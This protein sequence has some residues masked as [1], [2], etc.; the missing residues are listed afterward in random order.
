MMV[1]EKKKTDTKELVNWETGDHRP[2]L[3]LFSFVHLTSRDFKFFQ[4]QNT[5]ILGLK[6]LRKRI[7]INP[8]LQWSHKENFIFQNHMKYS[9][10]LHHM[11]FFF[12][13]ITDGGIRI[14]KIQIQIISFPV[15]EVSIN[16]LLFKIVF[17]KKQLEKEKKKKKPSFQCNFKPAYFSN[18]SIFKILGYG[19]IN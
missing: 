1:E 16:L 5:G 15:S 12:S 17:R 19:D 14:S 6:L 4:L 7:A 13:L 8:V 9:F 2:S 18:P 11:F 3:S 10:I